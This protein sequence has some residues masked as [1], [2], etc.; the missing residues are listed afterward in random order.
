MKKLFLTS[1][2]LLLAVYS[3]TQGCV[4]IRN[5][6]G[7]SPDLLFENIQPNDRLIL[8][9]TNRYF[10]A[11]STFIGDKFIT[12]SLVTN[13][14]YTLNISALR[15]LNNGWSLGLNVPVSANSRRNNRD[16]G[17]PQ[18]PKYTTRSF[19]LGDIRFTVYKWLLDPTRIKKGNIQ[20]G[21]GLKLP[22]GDFRYQDYFYRNDST[23]VLAPVDQSI[24][25][26]DGGTGISAELSAF[27][28]LN[29][30]IHIFVHGYYLINPREQNGVSNLKGRN[31]TPSE[32]INDITVMSVPDQYSFRGGANL[33]FHKIVLTAGLRYEKVPTED[34]IGGNKGFR[35]AASITSIEPG[36]T[37]KLKKALVFVNIAV[38]F[39]R[40]MV[41]SIPNIISPGGFADYLVFIGTQFKL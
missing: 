21:L 28:S 26:G 22:T 6:A 16:H 27:Y 30:T 32:I 8:N 13:R 4:A 31:A 14:I 23:K 35:R 24:Q 5:V 2:H 20:A 37:Y 11:S 38:P 36:V 29:K 1:F 41:Q 19:G 18:T 39:K 17:G 40:K 9:V 7:I 3:W 12:D 34:L 15:I 33:Q 10:E 25:L